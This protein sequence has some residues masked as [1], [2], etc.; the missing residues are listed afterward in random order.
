MHGLTWPTKRGHV[1]HA[2]VCCHSMEGWA[3][4]V[5]FNRSGASRERKVF[6]IFEKFDKEGGLVILSPDYTNPSRK[7]FPRRQTHRDDI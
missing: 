5:M 6:I 1:A 2:H 3:V 4:M 7:N